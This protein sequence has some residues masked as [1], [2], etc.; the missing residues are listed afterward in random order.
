MPLALRTFLMMQQVRMLLMTR[1][2][3]HV[4]AYLHVT[5]FT[6]SMMNHT[7]P[8]PLIRWLIHGLELRFSPRVSVSYYWHLHFAV[9]Y[10]PFSQVTLFVYFYISSDPMET[11]PQTKQCKIKCPYGWTCSNG[12]CVRDKFYSDEMLAQRTL[13]KSNKL[14]GFI[15]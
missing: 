7:S 2:K 1:Q 9:C 4:T 3:R 14:C 12:E 11:K 10:N 5:C 8:A 15:L 13:Y 6:K